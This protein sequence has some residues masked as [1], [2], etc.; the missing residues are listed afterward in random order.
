MTY[1]NDIDI[2]PLTNEGM[3]EWREVGG[4]DIGHPEDGT[5]ED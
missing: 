3:T 4:Q 2:R 1:G 5:M